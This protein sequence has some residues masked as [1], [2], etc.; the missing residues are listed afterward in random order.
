MPRGNDERPGMSR[1]EFLESTGLT[2]LALGTSTFAGMS[3]IATAAEGAANVAGAAG[4]EPYNIL[5]ILT[6][7]ERYF[8]PT[9]LPGDYSLPGRERLQRESVSFTNHQ[10]ATSVCSSSR[11]VIYTGQHI[12]H[13]RVFD[14]LVC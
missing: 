4:G 7:Q 9:T 3:T 13:T 14:K 11:S 2:T 8:D 6:D 1:R 10:I 5:F 12:Q